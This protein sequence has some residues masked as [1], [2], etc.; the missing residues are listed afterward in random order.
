MK[1]KKKYELIMVQ[2][3]FGTPIIWIYFYHCLQEKF[4]QWVFF[5]FVMDLEWA[6]LYFKLINLEILIFAVGQI[7]SN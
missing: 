1:S 5:V 6:I 7:Q 3:G 2:N 4:L